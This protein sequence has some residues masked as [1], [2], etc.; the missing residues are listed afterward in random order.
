MHSDT[1]HEETTFTRRRL[2]K[3][4]ATAGAA[5]AAGLAMPAC[6]ASGGNAGT[7]ADGPI[8]VGLLFSLSG[9][10]SI[11]ERSM[12]NGAMLA[13]EEL[14][15]AGGIGGRRIQPVVEDYAS[16]FSVVVQKARKLVNEDRVA[17]TVGCYSSASRKA[18]LPV[19]QQGNAEI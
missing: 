5:G 6:S 14:N 8:K 1:T 10:L 3:W 18:V 15:A 17:A 12:H 16:D 9:N 4:A 2:L 7:S 13:I 19:Y 11:A